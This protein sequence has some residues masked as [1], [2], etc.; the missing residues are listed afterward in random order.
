MEPRPPPEAITLGQ[1]QD[2]LG[3]R[4]VAVGMPEESHGCLVERAVGEAL[5]GAVREAARVLEARLDT[6]T[7]ADLLADVLRMDRA[8]WESKIA[9]RLIAR[10][11]R[12]VGRAA[13]RSF[14]HVTRMLHFPHGRP[15][16]HRRPRTP[17]DHGA[18][19]G[20]HDDRR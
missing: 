3:Q 2:A 10:P 5:D 17:R 1:I 12:A 8:R 11:A 4:V 18:A 19:P 9:S 7:V 20:A 13:R 6:I 16:R 15:R 14:Q